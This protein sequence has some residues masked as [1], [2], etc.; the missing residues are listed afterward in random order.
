M[1][2]LSLFIFTHVA[3]SKG[4]KTFGII[5]TVSK[6]FVIIFPKDAHKFIVLIMKM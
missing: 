4:K 3:C 1:S 2:T 6:V 5:A